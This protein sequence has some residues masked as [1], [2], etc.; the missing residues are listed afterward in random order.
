MGAL[1]PVHG[2]YR[3]FDAYV[4]GSGTGGRIEEGGAGM[5]KSAGQRGRDMWGRDIW[6]FRGAIGGG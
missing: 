6:R 2:N 3:V 5:V 1:H 4:V